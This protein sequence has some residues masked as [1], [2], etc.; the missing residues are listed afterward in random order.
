VYRVEARVPGREL[1]W[2][3]SNA[4]AVLAPPD[5]EARAARA[6]WPSSPEPP[7]ATAVLDA[8]EGATSFAAEFDASSA[9]QTAVVAPAAGPDG[10]AAARLAFRLGAPGPG[11]P[12]TWC[13]LVSRQARDLSGASGLVFS[14]RADRAY[15][16]W[17]QVR[18]L[19]PAS[20]D[21]RTEWWFASVRAEPEWRRVAVP[22]A[23]LRSINPKTDGRLDL[24][25]VRQLV[26]VLDGGAVKPG[27]EGTLWLDNLGLY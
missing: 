18:D 20:A 9:M 22:F 11:R 6:A 10:S 5:A 24:D 25:K 1:P 26:F 19:N 3:L 13:A 2:V 4:I 23:S 7:A 14:V 21:E 15:R 8:F 17:V 12:Y 27:T 16:I